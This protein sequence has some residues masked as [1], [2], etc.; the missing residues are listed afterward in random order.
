MGETTEQRKESPKE[1]SENSHTVCIVSENV[2][3]SGIEV[4]IVHTIMEY[5]RKMIL[6]PK[7]QQRLIHVPS[8]NQKFIEQWGK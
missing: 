8:S 7:P 2:P 1:K 5:P 3:L 4:L 6:T